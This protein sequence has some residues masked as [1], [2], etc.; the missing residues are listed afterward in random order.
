MALTIKAKYVNGTLEPLE[1]LKLKEGTVVTISLEQD[2]KAEEE[3]D[4]LL[5][6][7]EKIWASV[8]DEVWEGMP[9]DG[10]INY[11]HYLYGHPK[12]EK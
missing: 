9:T 11:R 1:P 4:S 7:M 2:E 10:S 6:M 12:E 8:P 3:H 5:E